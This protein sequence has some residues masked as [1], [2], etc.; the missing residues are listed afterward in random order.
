M[1]LI[2]AVALALV[3]GALGA[4]RAAAQPGDPPAICTSSATIWNSVGAGTDVATMRAV[5][6]QTPA[7][8]RVLLSRIDARIA[9]LSAP[10]VSAPQAP[11]DPCVRAR[12]D[13]TFLQ[14]SSDLNALQTFVRTTSSQCSVQIAQAQGRITMLQQQQAAAQAQQ[15]AARR[16]QALQAL[17]GNWSSNLTRPGDSCTIQVRVDGSTVSVTMNFYRTGAT[18]EKRYSIVD[19]RTDGIFVANHQSYRS[20]GASSSD[21]NM[22]INQPFYLRLNGNFLQVYAYQLDLNARP[23]DTFVRC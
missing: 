23:N 11:A 10:R 19:Q 13:W 17:A 22:E 7:A 6:T 8:C 21:T 2:L 4:T 16:A 14:T 9:A 12:A 3:L 1:R 5:R 18:I 15:S 20:T